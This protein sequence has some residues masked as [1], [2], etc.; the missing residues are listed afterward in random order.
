[1]FKDVTLKISE[2]DIT[3]IDHI[4]VS[5]YA[6]LIIETK[7]MKGWI[8]GTAKQKPRTRQIYRNKY[9]PQNP[10]RQNYK[11][12]K[13]ITEVIKINE[14][15]LIPLVIFVGSSEFKKG[16]P[17]GVLSSRSDLLQEILCNIENKL[18]SDK[19]VGMVCD[20]I[21]RLSMGRG[22]KVNKGHMT[23]LMNNT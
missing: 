10:T 1:V 13:G 7:N 14:K 4:V 22:R 9:K 19:S 15:V 5:A 6:I 12:V 16:L 21:G 20:R 11:H 18:L 23:N 17:D 3:Q 2:G 8:L